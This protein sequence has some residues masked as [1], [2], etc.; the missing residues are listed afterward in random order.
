VT[1]GFPAQRLLRDFP[2]TKIGGNSRVRRAHHPQLPRAKFL[3]KYSSEKAESNTANRSR[4]V[5]IQLNDLNA[6]SCLTSAWFSVEDGVETNMA[7]RMNYLGARLAAVVLTGAACLAAFAES[8]QTP[9][10]KVAAPTTVR[11]TIEVSGGDKESPVENASVYLKYVQSHLLKDKKI[12]LNV[13]TN[14][15]GTAHIPDAPMG[16]V[17]IQVVADG[18]K[19]YGKSFEVMEPRQTIK[20]HLEKPPKW[21]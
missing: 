3:D 11:L 6:M 16:K 15:E 12:E 18:W 17:L 4:Q 7:A 9:P 2:R 5:G 10:P 20:V 14:H 21:Y 8:S 13:K 19:T 1:S